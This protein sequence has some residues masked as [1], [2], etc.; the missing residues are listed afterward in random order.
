MSWSWI[1]SEMS[2]TFQRGNSRICHDEDEESTQRLRFLVK[3]FIEIIEF[4]YTHMDI[5][6]HLVFS[7]GAGYKIV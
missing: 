3:A 5:W 7:T 6:V 2:R 4:G 1:A